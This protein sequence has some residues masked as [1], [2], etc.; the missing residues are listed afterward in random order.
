MEQGS[1]RCDVNLSLSPAGSGELGTRSETKNVNSLRSVERA[2][3]SEMVR[4]GERALLRWARGAGDAALPRGHRPHDERAQQGAG[5]GLPLLPEP[6]LVPLAPAR[7]WVE[8]LRA[9]LPELP[10]ERRMRFAAEHGFS[11]RDMVAMSAAGW[12]TSSRRPSRRA[13]RPPTARN[14]WL[15][16]LLSRANADGVDPSALRITRRTSPGWW[17]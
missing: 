9:A 14:W 13:R 12:S 15:G 2:I 7:D 3:R 4:Q 8:E 6:D 10:R 16:D 11:G 17:R 1:L 5:R